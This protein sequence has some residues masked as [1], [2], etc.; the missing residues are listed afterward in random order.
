MPSPSR[1]SFSDIQAY[2]EAI[3]DDPDNKKSVD[4]SAHERFWNVP[5]AQF[6]NGTVPNENCNGSAIPIANKDPNKCSF[7]QALKSASGWCNLSQMPQRGPYITDPGY[8][9]TLKNGT[10]ISGAQIDA[11]IVWWLTNGMPEN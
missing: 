1:V 4:N 11:N 5:Y 2:L 6:V 7:Y 3:A 9:V 8:K 10:M